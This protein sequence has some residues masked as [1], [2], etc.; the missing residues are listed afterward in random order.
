MRKL[1]SLIIMFTSLNFSFAEEFNFSEKFSLDYY[2]KVKYTDPIKYC[3]FYYK[4]NDVIAEVANY[5]SDKVYSSIVN[6][7]DIKNE[8]G[9]S[10]LGDEKGG[11]YYILEGKGILIFYHVSA[12]CVNNRKYDSSMEDELFL[13]V[14]NS[15]KKFYSELPCFFIPDSSGIKK[16]TASSFL[17][18]GKTEYRAG[19]LLDKHYFEIGRYVSQ[20]CYNCATG[21]WVEGN[22]SYGIGEYL[23]VEFDYPSDEIQILNGYVDFRKIWLYKDNSRVKKIKIEDVE[24]SFSEEYELDDEVKYSLIKLPKKVSKIRITIT[25]VYPGLKYCDT[26]LSSIVVTNPEKDLFNV[27]KEKIFL[28]LNEHGLFKKI[29]D[30]KKTGIYGKINMNY[31][32]DDDNE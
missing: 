11:R 25:D 7:N 23:D 16:I 12:G 21:P 10:F 28:Y 22:E 2:P 3:I 26:C 20:Y 14:I 29:D 24:R 32:F 15:E 1:F 18:E 5:N 4:D 13:D 6:V 31:F 30:A 27:N 17:R 19:N 8:N 9:F